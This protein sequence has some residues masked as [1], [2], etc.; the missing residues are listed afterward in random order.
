MIPMVRRLDLISLRP[1]A[2]RSEVEGLCR[3]ARE[4]GCMAVCV[5]GS[6]VALAAALLEDSEVKVSALV[7]FPFGNADGDVKRYE[8]ECGVDAGAQEFDL[9][10]NLGMLKDGNHAALLREL[11]D[12]RE[13]AEERPVKAVIELALLSDEEL[14]RVAGVVLEAE[15]QFLVTATG[16]AVRPTTPGDL[17]R[18]REAV[19]PELG[20]KA[21][22][23]IQTR[24]D[25]E[26]LVAAGANRLGVFRTGPFLPPA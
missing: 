24:E 25:A 26:A 12:G 19:G 4:H 17:L 18:L 6:R 11:R 5:P 13:A 16:C 7:G 22:G 21:V 2:G 14:K 8:I 1:D 3:E 15:L 20:L 23:M 9:V 10:V